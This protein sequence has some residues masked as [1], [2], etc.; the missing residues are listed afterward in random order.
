MAQRTYPGIY[1]TGIGWKR[2]SEN[3]DI[4]KWEVSHNK[5]AQRNCKSIYSQ[6]PEQ[7]DNKSYQRHKVGQSNRELR[8]GNVV[9]EYISCVCNRIGEQCRGESSKA[10]T[11]RCDCITCETDEK[12][13][14][15]IQGH[16]EGT[17]IQ[18]GSSERLLHP[19]LVA[20]EISID[21][22]KFFEFIDCPVVYDLEVKDNHNYCITEG[23][24]IVHNISQA[25]TQ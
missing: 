7:T 10:Q 1:E 18:R 8:M 12:R 15:E 13:G 4:Q 16:C 6:S 3:N 19:E 25:Q 23:N 9:G 21:E 2:L 22:I 20:R 5:D 24:I 14:D 11:D 17:G